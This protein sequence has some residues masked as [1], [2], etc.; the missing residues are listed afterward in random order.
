MVRLYEMEEAVDG[1]PETRADERT[2]LG[3]HSQ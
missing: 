3:Q 2:L 1:T